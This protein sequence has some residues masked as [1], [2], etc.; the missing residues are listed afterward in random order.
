MV[1]PVTRSR[2]DKPVDVSKCEKWSGARETWESFDFVLGPFMDGLGLEKV[3]RAE[4]PEPEDEEAVATL[5]KKDEAVFFPT[6]TH[7]VRVLPGAARRRL[8]I[9][10]GRYPE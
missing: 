2:D 5:K 7:R 10:F 6:L 9:D 3:M 4:E 1:A 8:F